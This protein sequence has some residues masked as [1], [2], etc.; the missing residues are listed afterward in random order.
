MQ[1]DSIPDLR[2]LAVDWWALFPWATIVGRG[3][4]ILLF[5]GLA[6]ISYRILGLVLRRIERSAA[7]ADP[8]TVSVHEQRVA[9]LLGLVR[10]VG[11]VIIGII[12]LFMILTAL[13]IQ[14]GPLL[15]GAG[16]VGLAISFGAQSLVRDIL[17]GLF[18]LFENQFGVGDVIRIGD[19][20]GKVE[21]MTLRIVV[22]RDIQGTVHVV[23]NGEI[24]RVS[25]LTRSFSRAVIDIRV[26]FREDVER[27]MDVMR[28]LGARIWDDPDWK[29]LLMEQPTVPGIESFDDSSVTIRLLATT[30]P[31]KQWDVARELRR[32]LKRRFDEEGIAIPFPH[33]T[34]Y[35]G[36]GQQPGVH[37]L[38]EGGPEVEEG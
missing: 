27:V 8:S 20:A 25:N 2:G 9:T 16:V 31:L 35:W 3:S 21:K 11:I 34:L 13:G 24:K 7:A 17:S 37:E 33:R 1:T 28:D 30:V 18:I 5:L 12:T 22:M 23:P 32:R 14:I 38:M 4:Q 19:A 6:W 15:A 29:P 36:P 26:G 10:S